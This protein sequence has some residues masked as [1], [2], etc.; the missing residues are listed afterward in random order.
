MEKPGQ[1][2]G[3]KS[4]GVPRRPF[5]QAEPLALG[6]ERAPS[7]EGIAFATRRNSSGPGESWDQPP[8]PVHQAAT[9]GWSRGQPRHAMKTVPRGY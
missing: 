4:V 8:G 7:F 3:A 6:N 1:W 2:V 5:I 9:G